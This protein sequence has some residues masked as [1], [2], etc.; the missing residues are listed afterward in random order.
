MKSLQ[1]DQLKARIAQPNTNLPAHSY[2]HYVN[3][4]AKLIKR[5]YIATAKLVERWPLEKIIRRY[6]QATKHC[7]EKSKPDIHWWAMRKREITN[8]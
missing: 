8:D 4:T 1:F 7:P 2:E 3:L 6:E 5:S